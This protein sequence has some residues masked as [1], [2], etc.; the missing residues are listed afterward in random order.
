MTGLQLLSTARQRANVWIYLQP[1]M[2][3]TVC[4]VMVALPARPCK[5]LSRAATHTA[6]ICKSEQHGVNK[7]TQQTES[8][9]FADVSRQ[10]EFPQLICRGRGFAI[11]ERSFSETSHQ[12]L[13]KD[14]QTEQNSI[15]YIIL[16][17]YSKTCNNLSLHVQYT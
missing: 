15:S 12:L 10:C 9:V 3:A 17:S 2:T 6:G 11:N 14:F 1:D 5:Y 13:Q 7:L 4:C 16:N 8:S